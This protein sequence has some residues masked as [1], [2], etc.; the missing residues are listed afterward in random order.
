MK[1][2]LTGETPPLYSGYILVIS[3]STGLIVYLPCG[4]GGAPEW[5]CCSDARRAYQQQYGLA[6]HMTAAS[7]IVW[8]T[9]GR[10]G[11]EFEYQR[12]YRRGEERK[13]QIHFNRSLLK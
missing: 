11:S 6:E 12:F 1:T 4:A 13:K 9:L 3:D 2:L 10:L 8:T 7:H 5:L